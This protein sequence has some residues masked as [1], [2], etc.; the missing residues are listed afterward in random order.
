MHHHLIDNSELNA[1]FSSSFF[2]IVK[3]AGREF[4]RCYVI[5][6]HDNAYHHVFSHMNIHSISRVR[7]IENVAEEKKRKK[8]FFPQSEKLD[9]QIFLKR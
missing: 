4:R 7:I 3:E 2:I 5:D 9:M 6:H 1:L 8:L